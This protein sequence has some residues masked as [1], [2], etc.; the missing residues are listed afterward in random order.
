M[1]KKLTIRQELLDNVNRSGY[2]TSSKDDQKLPGIFQRIKLSKDQIEELRRLSDEK[3][4]LLTQ[5]SREAGETVLKILSPQQQDKF[6][7][8]IECQGF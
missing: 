1:L 3:A 6:L 7:D 5:Y 2:F 8:A 4:R